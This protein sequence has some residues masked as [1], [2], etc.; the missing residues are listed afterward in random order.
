MAKKKVRLYSIY[1]SIIRK[2]LINKNNYYHNSE[3]YYPK[4]ITPTVVWINHLDKKQRG[5]SAVFTQT[6]YLIINV[7]MFNSIGPYAPF[8]SRIVLRLTNQRGV[9]SAVIGVRCLTVFYS[10]VLFIIIIHTCFSLTIVNGL[11]LCFERA[12]YYLCG[13]FCLY[14][15]FFFSSFVETKPIKTI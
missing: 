15:R 1:I 8:R 5:L 10:F 11:V 6:P 7:E 12:G 2:K 13:N 9:F 14:L 3:K 4:N